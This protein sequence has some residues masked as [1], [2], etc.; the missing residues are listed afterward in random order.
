MRTPVS[1]G[2]LLELVREVATSLAQDGRRVK[3]CV[4][5]AMGQ[6]VFQGTP[7]ALSGVMRIMTQMDWGDAAEFITWGNYGTDAVDDADVYLLLA[8]QNVTGDSVLPFMQD[9]VRCGGGSLQTVYTRLRWMRCCG[10]NNSV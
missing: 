2:T 4:Q 8:P 1:S 3:V 7:L 9:M 5:Q 6:G 10:F